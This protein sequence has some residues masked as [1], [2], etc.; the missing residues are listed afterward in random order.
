MTL[1]PLLLQI[2]VCPGCRTRPAVD[3]DAGELHCSACALAYPV[4]DGVPV[5]V[6]AEARRVDAP[7]AGA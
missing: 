4:R 7:S 5:M 2:L 6:A 1:S 3:D